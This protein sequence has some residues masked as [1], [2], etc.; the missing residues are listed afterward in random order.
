[1][2]GACDITILIGTP[3]SKISFIK[4]CIP[5]GY[6]GIKYA[7]AAPD[8]AHNY[9]SG[10]GFQSISHPFCSKDGCCFLCPSI[11]TTLKMAAQRFKCKINV[12]V[13]N[14]FCLYIHVYIIQSIPLCLNV[15]LTQRSRI[16]SK[17]ILSPIL[18]SL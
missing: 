18:F 3:H 16:S 9:Q 4:N 14:L 2:S 6:L 17:Y 12:T 15:N 13:R 11:F 1:M 10:S 5:T 7:D 8:A